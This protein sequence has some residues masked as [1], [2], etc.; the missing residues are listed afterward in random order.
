MTV[1]SWLLLALGFLGGVD[2]LLFHTLAHRIRSHRPARAELVTHA[3]RGPTYALL[4]IVVPNVEVHGAW[5]WA[6]M[7][8][9]AFDLAISVGDF[10]LERES[11]AALGGLPTG[12]YLLHVV[13]GI[14]YGAFVAAIVFEAGIGATLS[15]SIRWD[16]GR[17]P[18]L[19]R[20]ALGLLAPLVLLSGIQD[21]LAVRALRR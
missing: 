10:C 16:P 1:A 6:L 9:V 15:T 18:S 21:A 2:I 4:F 14:V 20:L 12:E 13:M 11:R 7:A 19:L 5:F 17:V 8:L 3:L